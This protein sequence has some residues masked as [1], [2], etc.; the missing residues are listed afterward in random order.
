MS[1]PYTVYLE[2]TVPVSVSIYGSEAAVSA[3]VL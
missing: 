1:I 3:C 2:S